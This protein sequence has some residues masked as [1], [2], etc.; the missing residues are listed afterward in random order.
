MLTPKQYLKTLFNRPK[1]DVHLDG[2]RGYAIILVL[3]GHSSNA[4]YYLYPG[5]SFSGK[6]KLGVYLFFVLS[7]YLLDR[8][9]IRKLLSRKANSNYWRYYFTRRFLRIYPMY[10]TSLLLFFLLYK[11]GLNIAIVPDL[12]SIANHLMLV[13]GN[14]IFWSIPAEFKYYLISPVVLLVVHHLL[15]W[16]TMPVILFLG[17]MF[18]VPAWVLYYH[19]LPADQTLPHLSFF[20]VGTAVAVFEQLLPQAILRLKSS[21]VLEVL[22]WISAGIAI[23]VASWGVDLLRPD[24]YPFFT[25]WFAALL[26]KTGGKT[27]LFSWI[28]KWRIVQAIGNI[29]FSMYLG[30]MLILT[31]LGQFFP[32]IQSIGFYVFV[33]ATLILS[34]LSHYFVERPLSLVKIKG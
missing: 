6:G 8:Q 28:S 11:Q 12:K 32:G 2:L 26:L 18:T 31:A 13:E 34:L 7:A 30:H 1:A 33:I 17:L 15:Q 27:G 25:L 16:R 4:G 21:Y 9:I 14:G 10:F 20:L 24:W 29:S 23:V 3:L 5:I 22:L 19:L